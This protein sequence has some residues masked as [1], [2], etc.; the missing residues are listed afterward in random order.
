MESDNYIFAFW[1]D[2]H[3][4]HNNFGDEL[5]PYIISKLSGKKVIRAPIVGNRYRRL[6]KAI[7]YTIKGI[8]PLKDL[9]LTLKSLKAKSLLVS[10]GSIISWGSGKNSFI[11]GAGIIDKSS[12]IS[13]SEFLAVRGKYT[14]KRIDDI[15]LK[16][17]NV[18]YGDPA[19]LLP[20]IFKKKFKKKFPI[21]IIPHY[22]HFEEVLQ[23]VRDRDLNSEILVINLLDEVENVLK[24]ILQCEKIVSTSLHGL[25]VPHAYKIPALWIKISQ[26]EIAG[27]NIKFYDYFSSVKIQEYQRIDL[28]DKIELLSKNLI[29]EIFTVYEKFSRPKDISKVQSN[30]LKCAPFKLKSE[31]EENIL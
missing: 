15:G 14:L 4:K 6:I 11:W 12:E 9:I 27:D 5:N 17:H 16:Y 24:M 19:I 2:L 8:I 7:Y 18:K 21:G 3:E 30:L 13:Q 20:L 29:D 26:N 10:T 31:Y 23:I 1:Y 22:I 25:I 28:I